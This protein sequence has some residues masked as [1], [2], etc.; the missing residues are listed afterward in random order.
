M[1][2]SIV[3]PNYNGKHLLEKNLPKVLEAAGKEV[4]IIVV[5]DCSSDGSVE[6]LKQQFGRLRVLQHETNL[7]FGAACNTGVKAA[8]SDIVVL[9]NSDVVPTRD[10][11]KPLIKHFIEDKLVFSVGCKEIENLNGKK[12]ESG[13]TEGRFER[14]LF[15]HWRPKD[16]QSEQTMW[17]VGGSMAVDRKK[18]LQLGGFDRLFAPAYWEDID[19]VW[20]ARKLGWKLIF[21][22]ESVVYHEHE[23]TNKTV[24]GARKIEILS[25]RNQLLFVWKNFRGKEFQ[26]HL[27]WLP[28][29]LVFSSVRSKGAFFVAFFMALYRWISYKN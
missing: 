27:L 7:R 25:F 23:S 29:H 18:Y 11:L 21:E 3:I 24:F 5:D 14:G 1:K 16:Q 19:L 2:T 20:R 28:Y 12:V 13:R 6:M 8:N 17:T 4:E 15:I 9:L 22:K 10:F 26:Q